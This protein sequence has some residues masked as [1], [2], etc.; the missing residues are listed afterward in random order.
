DLL[1]A[2]ALELAG[3]ALDRAVP[4]V[5]RHALRLRLVDGEPQPRIRGRITAARAGRDRDLADQLRED[6]AALRVL[7][8]FA[9]ADVCP[10]AVTCHVTAP[11]CRPGRLPAGAGLAFDG[12]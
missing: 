1:V 5:L 12:V 11:R 2:D 8:A 4:V 9:K 3:A 10:L 6:L 7:R